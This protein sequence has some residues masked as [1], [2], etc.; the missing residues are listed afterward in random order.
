VVDLL[1]VTGY[2]QFVSMM[3]NVDGYPLPDGAAP[4]L[5]SLR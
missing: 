5:K 3:L 1:A 4:E 2:Y